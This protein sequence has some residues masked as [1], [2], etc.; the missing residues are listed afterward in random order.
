MANRA[1]RV[2]TPRAAGWLG[3]PPQALKGDQILLQPRIMA[4]ADVVEAMWSHRPYRPA[5]GLD[6]ALAEIALNKGKLFD[7]AVVE[8]WIKL[9]REL[10]FNFSS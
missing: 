7:P 10:G 1:N 2:A 5:M 3:L 8:A 9:F 6:A 4:V